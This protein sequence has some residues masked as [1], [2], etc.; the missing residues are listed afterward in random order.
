MI[1]QMNPSPKEYQ[2]ALE[3]ET[4]VVVT[5]AEFYIT[6]AIESQERNQSHSVLTCY[7]AFFP[8]TTGTRLHILVV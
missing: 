8:L 4:L 7:L 6:K 5:C 2:R 1:K 3:Y